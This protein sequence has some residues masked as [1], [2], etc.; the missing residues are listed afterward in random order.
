MSSQPSKMT[1]DLP[2]QTKP[3]IAYIALGSNLNNPINQIR[4]AFLALKGINKTAVLAQSSLYR[5]APVGYDANQLKQVPDFINA[6][7]KVSTELTPLELLEAILTI[8]NNFGR[9]RPFANAPRILDMDLLLYSD[10]IMQS[11]KLTIPHPRMFERGFVLLPL[12]EIAPDL[13]IAHYGRATD[14]AQKCANQG[15][16]I[17]K[18]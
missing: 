6:V 2:A 15:V 18:N 1:K 3:N 7:A 10:T 16:E 9:E 5:T 8:E 11:Q 14:L 13:M 4:T 12:A 17:I